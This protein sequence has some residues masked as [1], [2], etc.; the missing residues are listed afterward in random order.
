MKKEMKEYNSISNQEFLN[1]IEE[2]VN[3]KTV[4]EM[5]S[6]DNIMKPPVLTTV[7]WFLIIVI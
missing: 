3:N 1:I 6:I 4:Q 5:K 2:L 7:I